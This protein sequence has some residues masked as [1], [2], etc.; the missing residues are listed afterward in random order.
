MN[1]QLVSSS[2]PSSDGFEIPK[3]DLRRMPTRPGV[4]QTRLSLTIA[5]ALA[6]AAGDVAREEGLREDAWIGLAIESERAV[7]RLA[8]D[9]ASAAR[10]RA[11]L[12]AAAANPLPP[13][14]GLPVRASD[15]AA[16]LRGLRG[17]QDAEVARLSAPGQAEVTVSA[18]IPFHST[19]AWQRG[20]IAAGQTLGEW[21]AEHLRKLP[22]GRLLWEAAAVEAGETLAEWVLGQA[23]RRPSA[24]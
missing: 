16:A 2:P 13:A 3:R 24:R 7:R 17:H 8:R 6:E 1:L 21:A 22:R 5:A 12:D 19:A 15:F 10:F 20:A 18:R 4:S 23:V 11:V 9:D 14:P